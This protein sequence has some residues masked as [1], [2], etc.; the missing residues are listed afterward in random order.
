MHGKQFL[1]LNQ[2]IDLSKLLNEN[3]YSNLNFEII[4]PIDSDA[5]LNRIN[6]DIF[7]RNGVNGDKPTHTDEIVLNIND[8]KFKY[9]KK[10]E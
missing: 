3:G 1:K 10:N 5:L 8:I 7:F 4:I 9:V 6:E 2:L